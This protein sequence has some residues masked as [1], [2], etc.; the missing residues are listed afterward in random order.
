MSRRATACLLVASWTLL[1]CGHES[2][3]QAFAHIDA[4]PTA[5]E[6]DPDVGVERDAEPGGDGTVGIIAA[7]E[8]DPCDGSMDDFD[9]I[10]ERFHATLTLDPA[11]GL[12]RLGVDFAGIACAD[13]RYALPSGVALFIAP[14]AGR[15]R[16]VARSDAAVRFATR[17]CGPSTAPLICGG[18][19]ASAIDLAAG[20]R[21]AI[22]AAAE[23]DAPVEVIVQR[24]PLSAID[25]GKLTLFRHPDS[26][27]AGV[28]AHGRYDLGLVPPT[29]RLRFFT[30]GGRR[31][32]EAVFRGLAEPVDPGL[33]LRGRFR[34]EAT[35][36]DDV[37]RGMADRGVTSVRGAVQD[38]DG[39]WVEWS[40]PVEGILRERARLGRDAPCRPGAPEAGCG[41]GLVCDRGSRC[42]R[43]PGVLDADLWLTVI[44]EPAAPD[45]WVEVRVDDPPSALAEMRFSSSA[46]PR[47]GL[48]RSD[49]PIGEHA[50]RIGPDVWFAPAPTDQPRAWWVEPADRP[51]Y[52]PGFLGARAYD[53]QRLWA[54]GRLVLG[55]SAAECRAYAAEASALCL[56]SPYTVDE[57][58]TQAR[59]AADCARVAQAVTDDAL[60][61]VADAP[62]DLRV[63]FVD[64]GALL[65]SSRAIGSQEAEGRFCARGGLAPCPGDD[66][67]QVFAGRP[68][69]CAPL[70]EA[71]PAEWQI[72][73]LDRYV[74]GPGVWGWFD[75]GA[76]P[77]Y[78]AGGG[79]CA[80]G[81]LARV[82]RFTAAEAGDY[83]AVVGDAEG[84]PLLFA[85]SHCPALGQRYEQACHDDFLAPVMPNPGIE[86]ALAAGQTV[87]LFV[88]QKG[89]GPEPGARHPRFHLRVARGPL[90][91]DFGQ[92]PIEPR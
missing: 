10:G 63:A 61:R 42:A 77:R 73:A 4:L 9:A 5:D 56:A 25:A 12:P 66:V 7:P 46:L 16:V 78:E 44:G 83:H 51:T 30:A 53:G 13:L 32:H 23:H 19:D 81:G 85:R 21:V 28:V 22:V 2:T 64:G 62:L 82:F 92:A 48:V 24:G 41:P 14:E 67:C 86:L 55:D 52:A 71:C 60:P 38:L 15:Y 29:L 84:D 58:C 57:D 69:W 80:D 17:R 72:V 65:R 50:I 34:I 76:G 75:D 40:A 8:G 79:S 91:P 18:L 39:R 33:P 68:P 20:E 89:R 47:V 43:Q 74:V 49:D 36:T 6:G 11:P 88:A 3:E 54:F 59:F 90:P 27:V 45:R 31:V 70:E 1:A 35:V 87:Y 26:D 37:F